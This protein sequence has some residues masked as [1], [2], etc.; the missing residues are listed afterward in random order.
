M[1]GEKI[2]VMEGFRGVLFENFPA[3]KTGDNTYNYS[4]LNALIAEIVAEEIPDA[5]KPSVTLDFST[6]DKKYE[7]QVKQGLLA[8]ITMT[9]EELRAA[10]EIILAELFD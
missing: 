10:E 6:L 8:Q 1:E 9:P 2:L 4:M 7:N 5:L 3:I